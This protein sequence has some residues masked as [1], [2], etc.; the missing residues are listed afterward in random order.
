MT[1]DLIVPDWGLILP[2]FV[3]F[4]T[5]IV[6]SLGDAFLPKHLHFGWLTGISLVGYGLGL[7]L[8]FDQHDR[9]ESTFYGLFRADGLT[10]FLSL[11]IL[12]AAIL[13]VL[14]SASYVDRLEGRM[15]L[16]EFYTLLAFSVLGALLTASAGD[17]V[18]LFVGIELSSL[19]TYILTAFAK[20]RVTS[21]EGALKYFLLGIFASAILLYG[22][23][24]VYGAAG[25][26]NLDVI[27]QNLQVVVAGQDGLDASLLLGVLLVIVGLGFKLA[28]VPFHFWTPDAYDGA[29]TPV[30][31]FMS[32][33]PK[34][35]AMAAAI[36]ILVQGLAPLRDD[37]ITLIAVLSLITM[38]F[39]NVVAISQR[40]VKR[41]LAYS[42]IAHTGYMMAGL[43]AYRA[44]EGFTAGGGEAEQGVSSVL[45][46]IFAYTFMNIGAFAVVAWIQHRGR[47]MELEDFS[48]LGSSHPLPAAAMTVFLISLMGIPPTIGFYGKYY[49]IVALI[50]ADLLWLA[51]AIVLM[52][53]VS[54]FFYLRVVA[55]MY[56]SDGA[57]ARTSQSTPL[58]NIG[59]AAMVIAVFALGLFSGNI[60]D[61]A[62]EWSGALT[63]ATRVTP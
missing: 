19:A 41:M 18:M 13:T 36:R 57:P 58:L 44:Q 11:I 20:R 50:D 33:V 62:D 32:V 47:G 12:S 8:L 40:N 29:P 2:Q 28:A 7:V 35:A 22:M 6:L 34:A 49:V 14:V 56:F 25:S 45:Y 43:A 24:W 26:T 5:T 51:L 48:G 42:S 3:V 59:I 16:G 10:V 54:A 60:V 17:L 38:V 52:S 30:T 63:L 31:A 46:Y 61:L 55:Q 27:A 1:F 21:L 9:N 37:W 39:G 53:A 23:A 4:I 15:P